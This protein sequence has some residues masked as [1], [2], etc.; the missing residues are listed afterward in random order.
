MKKILSLVL[1]LVLTLSM[2]CA[3]AEEEKIKIGVVQYMQHV[4]L[5]QANAGFVAA[6]EENGYGVDKVDIDQQNAQG[7]ASNLSTIADKFVNDGVDLVLAIATPAAQVMA[8]AQAS[9]PAAP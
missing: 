3:F 9:S 7:D 2:S 8:V 6:L 4:A 5:D 1:V